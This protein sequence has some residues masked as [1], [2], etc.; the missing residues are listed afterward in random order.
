MN[1]ARHAA[2]LWRFRRITAVGLLLGIFLA[3]YASYDIT[4]SGLVRRGNPTYTSRSQLLVTQAGCP[5]C[6]SVLPVTPALGSATEEPKVDP[7]QVEFA[8]P[9]RF[10]TLADLYTKLVVSDEVLAS[11]PQHPSPAQ[12]IASPLPA[13]SGAPILPIIQLDTIAG[14]PE[15]AQRL[16]ADTGKALR[17]L[18]AREGRKNDVGPA[19]SVQI[20]TINAP[21]PGALAAGASYTASIL[22]L[23]LTLVGTVALTHLLENLRNRRD[24]DQGDE[25]DSWMV[26]D[27]AH[28]PASTNGVVDGELAAAFASEWGPPAAP[29]RPAE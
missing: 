14:S 26:D 11:I 1:L 13:V 15:A 21:S 20:E 2:V 5:E 29:Q 10:N 12:I 7:D 3:V 18:I 19:K 22:A 25:V 23:L 27:A 9:A 28:G 4:S 6:R 8:D 17:E 16:N 24:T